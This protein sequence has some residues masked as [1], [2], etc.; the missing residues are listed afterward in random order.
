[1]RR[2]VGAC[3]GEEWADRLQHPAVMVIVGGRGAGPG[4]LLGS[5]VDGGAKISSRTCA[6]E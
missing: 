5:G 2:G 3:N 1:V 4:G 6:T